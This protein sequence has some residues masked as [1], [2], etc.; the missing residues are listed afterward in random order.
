VGRNPV[1]ARP[2][3]DAS[4]TLAP[5]PEANAHFETASSWEAARAMVE[6]RPVE[7]SET[8][9][10]ELQSLRIHVMD[11]RLRT[12]AREA[13]ALE[14]HYGGFVLSEAM[15]VADEARRLALEVSYGRNGR[16]EQVAGHEG[17]AYEL[18]PEPEPDDIDGRP[19]AVVV[20]HDERMLYL[21]ASDTLS[22]TQ[23]LEIARSLYA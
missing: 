10:F 5:M 8:A 14:A 13:R 2:L 3:I 11:H 23:L 7:P 6:F 1:R 18:G 9:G 17:R 19:P 21:V 15:H 20:W 12:L 16:A 22:A 4:D